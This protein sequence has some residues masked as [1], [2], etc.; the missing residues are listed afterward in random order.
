MINPE[1]SKMSNDQYGHSGP[2][3]PPWTS[4]GQQGPSQTQQWQGQAGQYYDPSQH[5][6]DPNSPHAWQQGAHLPGGRPPS[7]PVYKKWWFWS[8]IARSE[9]RRVGKESS[10][11]WLPA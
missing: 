9:E 6:Y 8:V 10:P 4:P 3:E 7:E 5:Y 1:G 11:R 2:P